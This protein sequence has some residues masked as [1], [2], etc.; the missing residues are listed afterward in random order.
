M[1]ISESDKYQHVFSASTFNSAVR[2]S[3]WHNDMFKC[4]DPC[5]F[6]RAKN[7]MS[8]Q[9]PTDFEWS[10]KLI[11]GGIFCV[12]IASE[13]KREYSFI[14]EYD[15]NAILYWFS[16]SESEIAD[17]MGTVHSNLKKHE[18]GDVIRFRFQPQTKKLLIDLV[19]L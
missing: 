19:S 18:S 9:S 1:N 2:S 15:S 11:G 13:L 5:G 6:A 10:V 8:T 3:V 12:G 16:Q 17:G 7:V 14:D 4:S